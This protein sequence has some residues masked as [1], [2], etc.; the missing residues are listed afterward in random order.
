MWDLL[1]ISFGTASLVALLYAVW[2]NITHRDVQYRKQAGVATLAFL[3]LTVGLYVWGP[4]ASTGLHRQTD[5][6][7]VSNRQGDYIEVFYPK[8]FSSPPNLKLRFI[9]GNGTLEI[10]DQRSDGFRF[11]AKDMW[12]ETSE[13][14][15][16]EWAAA[17]TVR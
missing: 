16:V 2:P 1:Q 10:L 15:F 3:L 13:G 4:S 7:E 5:T 12:Y 11:K 17:G 14:A 6:V 8:T 9:K